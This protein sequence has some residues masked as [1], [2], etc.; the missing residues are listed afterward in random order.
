MFIEIFS[1]RKFMPTSVI[2]CQKCNKN[3]TERVIAIT[4]SFDEENKKYT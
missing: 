2:V 4:D 3:I 1:G